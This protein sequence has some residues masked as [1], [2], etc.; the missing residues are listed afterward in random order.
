MTSLG[1]RGRAF[2]AAL[3][4]ASSLVG[5]ATTPPGRTPASSPVTAS[6]PTPT[7]V[8]TPTKPLA[9]VTPVAGE[10]AHIHACSPKSC[11]YLGV[12]T[13]NFPGPAECRV[14][15]TPTP[16]KKGDPLLKPWIQGPNETVYPGTIYGQ[17]WIE[18]DCGGIVG[19]T[20]PWPGKK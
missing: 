14:S 4:V 10:P 7:P 2:L 15:R 1:R 12:T 16:L 6:A 3:A 9:V 20:D 13:K 17:A 5:C 18:V 8:A 19:R 11:H